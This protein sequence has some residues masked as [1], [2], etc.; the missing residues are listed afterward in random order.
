MAVLLSA[1]KRVNWIDLDVSGVAQQWL[2]R[3]SVWRDDNAE[4]ITT[5]F[6]SW[7]DAKQAFV[8]DNNKKRKI[9]FL[10]LTTMDSLFTLISNSCWCLFAK[11]VLSKRTRKTGQVARNQKAGNVCQKMTGWVELSWKDNWWITQVAKF[12]S[13]VFRCAAVF[14]CHLV[15]PLLS[16]VVKTQTSFNTKTRKTLVQERNF[17]T[18]LTNCFDTHCEIHSFGCLQQ[19]RKKHLRD[20]SDVPWWISWADSWWMEH[21]RQ[22]VDWIAS[23]H[24]SVHNFLS[25]SDA[26]IDLGGCHGHTWQHGRIWRM[27]PSQRHSESLIQASKWKHFLCD[28]ISCE[29][30]CFCLLI[31]ASLEKLQ[32]LHFICSADEHPKGRGHGI[33]FWRISTELGRVIWASLFILRGFWEWW[34]SFSHPPRLSSPVLRHHSYSNTHIPSLFSV[35]DNNNNNDDNNNRTSTERHDR[36]NHNSLSYF[37]YVQVS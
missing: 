6:M 24:C 27:H 3:L 36:N 14:V 31:A 15:W 2:P 32:L 8:V 17:P 23:L 4:K 26:Q 28:S 7:C 5:F 30:S 37:L 34:Q 22:I 33:S 35:S 19:N 9:T 29:H 12:A 11:R 20:S 25:C 21:P 16:G 18:R 1:T 13:R 10:T